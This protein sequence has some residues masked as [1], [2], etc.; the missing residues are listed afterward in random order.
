MPSIKTHYFFAHKLY[1]QDQA[2]FDFLKKHED[3]LYLTAQG[4]D[5]LMFYGYVFWRKRKQIKE[6]RDYASLLHNQKDRIIAKFVCMFDYA[7]G[8]EKE[9]LHI[10]LTAIYGEL[11]HYILDS[12]LHPYVFYITG[13]QEGVDATSYFYDHGRFESMVDTELETYYNRRISAH[14]IV[15]CGDKKLAIINAMYAHCCQELGVSTYQDSVKDMRT[16][17]R[18]LQDRF[19]I[20]K[21]LMRLFGLK[22][23]QAYALSHFYHKPKHDKIDYLNQMKETWRFPDSGETSTAS[24]FEL[25]LEAKEAFNRV[26]SIFIEFDEELLATTLS[27]KSYDGIAYDQTFRYGDSIYQNKK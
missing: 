3:V 23:H 21:A 4:P 8:L 5:P 10:A 2:R 11:T 17:E 14:S 25:F 27:K 24:V 1:Q 12:H 15:A 7:L 22:K 6:I 13:F 18:L 20:K 19:G 16:I 26:S 9:E